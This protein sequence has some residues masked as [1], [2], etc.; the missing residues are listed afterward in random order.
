MKPLPGRLVLLGHPVAHSLSPRFQNAALAA[1]GVPL[2]Y[3]LLD[4]PPAE[5]GVTIARLRSVRAAGNVTV[6]HKAAVAALCD[7]LTPTAERIGAVNTFLHEGQALIG[8]NTDV[9]GFRALSD[10]VLGPDPRGLRVALL[11]AGGSAAAVCAVVESWEGARVRAWARGRA[12][13]DA[14]VARFPG[15][16]EPAASAGE[17]VR[18]ADVVVNSTPVGLHGEE[19]PIPIGSLP[20]DAAVMDLAYRVGET[21]WV[22]A[23]RAGGHRAADGQEMLIEQGAHAF[24]CWLGIV[25][26]RN[27]MRA[28]LVA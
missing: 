16:V 7:R 5:L 14:L 27:V 21:P 20:R 24:E 15:L 3:E 26:D 19:L 17:A 10:S 12:R 25:P 18:D 23:A 22:R 13:L 2:T 9:N 8:D 1:A 4:V 28:A 6:P 11:G